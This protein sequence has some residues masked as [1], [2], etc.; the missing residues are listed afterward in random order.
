MSAAAAGRRAAALLQPR[1]RL[2][3]TGSK[4]KPTDRYPRASLRKGPRPDATN[5]VV[6]AQQAATTSKQQAQ[7]EHE[8][9]LNSEERDAHLTRMEKRIAA[10]SVVSCAAAIVMFTLTKW[11]VER[12]VDELP[13]EA[14]KRWYDGTYVEMKKAEER[15]CEGFEPAPA[16]EGARPGYLF[17]HGARGLGYYVDRAGSD[18]EFGSEDH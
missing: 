12:Q 1:V 7:K 6:Q 18:T 3:A 11:E 4:Q 15:E 13:E 2:L 5:R 16:F 17:K 9:W 8:E 10:I 14:R